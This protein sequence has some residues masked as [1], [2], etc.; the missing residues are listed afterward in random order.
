[1]SGEIA[2]PR[3][4]PKKE[5]RGRQANRKS[6]ERVFKPLLLTPSWRKRAEGP[7][8]LSRRRWAGAFVVSWALRQ[9]LPSTQLPLP[10]SWGTQTVTSPV[11]DAPEGAAASNSM[12]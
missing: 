9:R 5:P 4:R 8:L 7:A 10:P 3:H 12:R 1:M 6:V 11:H 2:R